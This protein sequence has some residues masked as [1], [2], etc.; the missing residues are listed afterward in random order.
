MWHALRAGRRVL[1]H[2]DC[3]AIVVN[4]DP[5]AACLVGRQ[6]GLEHGLPVVHDLRDPWAPCSLRRPRRPLPQRILVDHLERSC[7][8]SAARYVLN[9]ETALEDYR[10][11]YRDVPPERFD[12]IRNHGDRELVRGGSYPERARYTLLFLGNFRRFVGGEVLVELLAELCRRGLGGDDLCLCVTGR[13]PHDARQLA[14]SAGVEAMLDEHPFVPYRE[15]GTFMETADVLVALCH[16]TRQR[17][18]AKIYDYATT[19]RPMLIVCDNP[20]LDR[21]L[22]GVEG[23]RIHRRIDVRRMADTIVAEMA[24]G[25]RR[26]VDRSTSGLDSA[27]ASAKLARILDE[28]TSGR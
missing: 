3:E 27:T 10:A 4:A 28:V 9:T 2:S 23:A 18:P 8:E 24:L 7:V 21:M 6:L 16:D 12:V 26:S 17:I 11:H 20:E 22:D 5:Y 19:D 1:A 15:V 14:R 13:V 25:R